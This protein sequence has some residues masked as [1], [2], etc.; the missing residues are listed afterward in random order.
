[1]QQRTPPTSDD[2]SR[3]SRLRDQ[4]QVI[5]PYFAS[6]ADDTSAG[7]SSNAG[8]SLLPLSSLTESTGFTLAFQLHRMTNL[9]LACA[10]SIWEVLSDRIRNREA[11]LKQLGWD[12]DDLDAQHARER[13]ELILER[14][15]GYVHAWDLA[16]HSAKIM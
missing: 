10:E 2:E 3:F 11:D 15:H 7:S 1:M 5:R 12:D 9:V 13:F 4:A 16:Q 6:P 14:Y 8:M